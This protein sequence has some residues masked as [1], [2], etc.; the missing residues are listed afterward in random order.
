MVA[1]LVV[2]EAIGLTLLVT[3]PP[4]HNAPVPLSEVARLLEREDSPGAGGPPG[5]EG[6]DSMGAPPPGDAG[7]GA[8]TSAAPNA[9]PQISSARQSAGT[10]VLTAA[11][12][13]W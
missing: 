3:R 6:V 2:A 4:I 10:C 12:P 8:I 7:A 1:A 13:G 11:A 5:L 9:R